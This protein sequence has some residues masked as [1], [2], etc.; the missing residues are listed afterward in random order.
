MH[1]YFPTGY[2]YSGL[3]V[4][5]FLAGTS[6]EEKTGNWNPQKR[7]SRRSLKTKWKQASAHVRTPEKS[8][9][10]K[11][12]R[13]R[14]KKK[15]TPYKTFK[16]KGGL[17]RYYVEQ[18]DPRHGGR[19]FCP[20]FLVGKTPASMTLSEFQRADS[21]SVNQRRG[22]RETTWSKIKGTREAH[23]N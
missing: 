11:K 17:C 14:K 20:P 4:S 16:T 10:V 6:P 7:P 8:E 3:S 22:S 18:R 13:E 23:Q 5:L 9:E 1:V 12:R 15:K 19:P 2:V 21:N